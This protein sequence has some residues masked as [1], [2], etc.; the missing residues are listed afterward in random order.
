MIF[1]LVDE[2]LIIAKVSNKSNLCSEEFTLLVE[3]FR[4]L[5][6]S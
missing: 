4:R 1:L 3:I 2:D 6:E 5:L